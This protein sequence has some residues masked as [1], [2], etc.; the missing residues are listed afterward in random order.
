MSALLPMLSRLLRASLWLLAGVLMLAA[1]Y[2][3]LGRQFMPLVAEYRSEIEEQLQ[4]SLQQNLQIEQLEGGWSGFSPLLTA[5]YVTLGEGEAALQVESLDIQPDILA[6][7]LAG[8]LRLRAVTLTGLQLQVLEDQHGHWALQGLVLQDTEQAAFHLNDFLAKL[9]HVGRLSVLDSRI[10]VQA[11]E[12]E[13]LVLT[14]AGFTLRQSGALRRFDLSAVLPDGEKLELS[15]QGQL[16]AGDWRKSAL[17]LYL[18]IPSSNLAQWLPQQYLQN[19][20]L[21]TV[22]AGAELWLQAAQGQVNSAA[23]RLNT[24][25]LHGQQADAEP[26]QIQSHDGLAWYQRSAGVQRAWFE[27]LLVQIDE[28]PARDLSVLASYENA[29][30]AQWRLALERLELADLHY[31][32]E[33]VVQLPAVAADV[34]HSM[35]PRGAL[36]NLQLQWRPDAALAERLEFVSNVDNIEFSAWHDVPASSGINGLIS[37]DLLQGELRLATDS[38]FSLHLANLFAKPWLYERAHAQL[39]WEFDDLGFTLKSPYLKVKGEEGDIA[40]DFLIRLFSDPA[41]EDYM[42]LRVGLRDGDASFTGKYL[43]TLVPD[44]GKD[45]AHWLNTAIQAGQIEQ[46]YFQYQGSLNKGTPPESRSLSLYFAVQDAR[47]EYQPGWPAL[48]EATAE[49]MIEDSGIRISVAQ[50][51]ILNSPISSAYA[52]IMHGAPGSIPLLELQAELQSSMDDGLYFLQKT[53]LALETL[54]FAKWRGKGSLPAVLNLQVPLAARQPVQVKVDLNAQGVELE[55][56]DMN[57]HLY[58]LTGAF[59]FDSQRGLSA[60]KV[61]GQFLG[62]AFAGDISAQGRAGELST[63]IDVRGLMPLEQLTTW[64]QI[65]EP[66]P[67]TGTLPYRLRVLLE[68]ADSQLRIDS[69]LLGVAI[70]LPAPFGKTASQESYAD[71][72]MTLAGQERRYWLD[73][74]D[75][76]SLSLAAAADNILAGRAQLRLGGGLA[77]LPT[78]AGLRVTG[79]LNSFDLERWQ[80]V[81]QR[82]SV[83]QT[84]GMQ[85]LRSAKL[86]LRRVQGFGLTANNLKIDYRPQQSGWQLGL[87]S[88]QVQGQ[89]VDPG[90]QQP[91]QV[92]LKHLRLPA[93][94]KNQPEQQDALADF[95]MRTIP[96]LNIKID[97]LSMGETHLGAFALQTR[98]QANG[99]LFDQLNLSLKGLHVDGQLGWQREK[100]QVSS[101][102][103][104]RLSGDNMADV[105]KAWDFA[106]SITSQNFRVDTHLRWSGSPAAFDLETLNGDAQVQFRKGQMSSVDGSA[107]A[108]RV[109]GLLN[110]DSIGR[111][112]RLD[113]SDLFGKGLAYDRI[114]GQLLVSKG[115]YRTQTPLVLEGPSSNFELDGQLNL[116]SDQVQAKLLVTLP[117]TNNLPL[118][119]IAIGA[120]AVGGALFLVDRLIGDRLSRFA[121]VTYHI[122]GDWQ[123]PDISLIKK[124][125]K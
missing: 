54:E 29:D 65:S 45:L 46:G 15:A 53:P 78:Q 91:L 92:Y 14:Y 37:G 11:A 51:K 125:A 43:P 68:G 120:P 56:P 25:E 67:V 60:K 77:R 27:R 110:F 87:E 95:D 5:R 49:V 30:T 109:F 42:D 38:G 119:A 44:F 82:Y 24:L 105:L 55:M 100:G 18:K 89:I 6:S 103:K 113:F 31:V 108:L 23:L 39:L 40:G 47:L 123:Q 81:L 9:Q 88:T 17:T 20:Q 16:I 124:P 69:S 8:E 57:L 118:A 1:L 96:A 94:K 76:A 21:T 71:W 70:D 97:A 10:L 66:L 72:R 106:P 74:A 50:G 101:W 83:P 12:R 80:A 3:S 7:V 52:E 4:Q 36:Q 13:P 34:L 93:A 22:K 48:T 102:Y 35:Q 115:V 84:E 32:L 86:D 98:P 59:V 85:F 90:A 117:L 64:A 63:H 75:Q 41:E 73:Y 28:L 33:R 111:R 99:V 2:V 79:R 121:S 122:S 58:K 61:T 112:L 116:V 19:W 104:G 26:L 114:K 107:Q 62:Q